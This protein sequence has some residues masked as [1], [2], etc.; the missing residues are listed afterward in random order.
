MLNLN[1][2]PQTA[3]V[4]TNGPDNVNNSETAANLL[5]N[6]RRNEELF[7]AIKYELQR[8]HYDT[9]RLLTVMGTSV[10]RIAIQPV[11]RPEHA[12]PNAITSQPAL[13]EQPSASNRQCRS[14]E[15]LIK[16]QSDLYT[17]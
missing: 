9:K 2:L 4:N 1:E 6:H 8:N 12:L 13:M 7:Q 11:V 10:R 15:K 17:L 16:M 3:A 5:S 14:L